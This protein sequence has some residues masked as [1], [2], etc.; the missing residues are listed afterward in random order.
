MS[1]G[2]N[3]SAVVP[4]QAGPIATK[5]RLLL[6]L[7]HPLLRRMGP[8]LRRDDSGESLL[9]IFFRGNKRRLLLVQT[10]GKSGHRRD[11]FSSARKF[12]ARRFASFRN[13]RTTVDVSP[14]REATFN[15]T[16][17]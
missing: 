13:C 8:R 17:I 2:T 4:A 15:G 16:L 9:L 11:F 1:F 10:R 3:L 14:R 7:P 5:V 6:Y 12:C